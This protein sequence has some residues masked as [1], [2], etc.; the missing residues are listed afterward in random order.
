MG[1]DLEAQKCLDVAFTLR[2]QLV[3]HERR[4]DVLLGE[5]DFDDLVIFWSK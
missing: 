5:A 4:L 2:R 3:P 1:Q